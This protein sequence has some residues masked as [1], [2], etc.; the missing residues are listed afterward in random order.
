[1]VQINP[2]VEL[3][4][5]LLWR[6]RVARRLLE[7]PLISAFNNSWI[8]DLASIDAD[9]VWIGKGAWALPQFWRDYRKRKPATRLVCYNADDPITSFSRGANRP[10]VTELI[11]CFDLFCTYK[12]ELEGPLKAH[13]ANAVAVIP[14]AWDPDVH[15]RQDD[16]P[17]THDIVFVG[18]G[19][20]HRAMWI[21]RLLSSP[22]LRGVQV[23][24]YGHWPP[25]KAET[26]DPTIF[27]GQLEGSR[28]A[29][30]IAGAKLSLNILRRQNETTHNM[31]TF[32]TPGCGGVNIS[33]YTDQ[34][35]SFF[36]EGEASYYFRSLDDAGDV[37]L[38]AIAD[39]AGRNAIRER[40][41]EIVRKH[42]YLDRARQLL[43]H[44][45]QPN[46]ISL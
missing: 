29:S 18:N 7:K 21:N 44:L 22:A 35:N 39:D 45:P 19:D 43:D 17:I 30:A 6:N 36:P 31:R 8:D 13:G 1:M 11:S 15:Q 4:R 14:F 37:I 10:W 2:Q 38:A 33:L 5:R 40:A 34:Q 26:I 3:E 23:A 27:K 16:A 46:V 9:M 41:G 28:M 42:T 12:P 25:V 20:Q 24:I 32:E